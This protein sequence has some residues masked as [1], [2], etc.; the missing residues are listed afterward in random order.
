MGLDSLRLS[1][2]VYVAFNN[3][4]SHQ[5]FE[6]THATMEKLLYFRFDFDVLISEQFDIHSTWIFNSSSRNC[7]N[8]I[9]I[10]MEKMKGWNLCVWNL[11]TGVIILDLLGSSAFF[12]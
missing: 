6:A 4:N 5:Q 9:L 10:A 11:M 2:N 3:R 8:K 1:E 12:S 7:K